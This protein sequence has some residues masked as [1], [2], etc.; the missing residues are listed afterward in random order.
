MSTEPK[1]L[2]DRIHGRDAPVP[3]VKIRA[4]PRGSFGEGRLSRFRRSGFRHAGRKVQP[5]EVITCDEDIARALIAQ[6]KAERA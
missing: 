5:G 3:Q 6:G 2:L 1:S 4:L